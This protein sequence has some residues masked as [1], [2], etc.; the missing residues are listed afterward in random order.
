MS[1]DLTIHS[2]F[3]ASRSEPREALTETAKV[4]AFRPTDMQVPADDAL[5]SRITL[6]QTHCADPGIGDNRE[7]V[8]APRKARL[9][10]GEDLSLAPADAA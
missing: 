8:L 9:E 5:G 7:R 3:R 10:T 2:F 1:G 4:A 6:G